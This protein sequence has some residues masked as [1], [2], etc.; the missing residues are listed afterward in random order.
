MNI[1]FAPLMLIPVSIAAWFLSSLLKRPDLF[2]WASILQCAVTVSALMFWL[3]ASLNNSYEM[4]MGA[5]LIAGLTT[6]YVGKTLYRISN[7]RK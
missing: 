5:G 7:T 4:G 6:A 3:F 2:A 1:L